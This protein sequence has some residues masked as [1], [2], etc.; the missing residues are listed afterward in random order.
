V[1][2]NKVN[3]FYL[4]LLF[5]HA[6]HVFEEAWGG[7]R[8]VGKIGL[9]WFFAVNWFLFSIPLVIFYFILEKRRGAYI[10]GMLYGA[11]MIINGLGH[12]IV[13]I[14]TGRYFGFAAGGFTGIGLILT[15]LP[16]VYYLNKE[17]R[18]SRSVAR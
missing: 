18:E 6:G 14:V 10:L 1:R 13:T 5:F 15:G 8:I 7:F 4:A 3:L 2:L 17:Y 12:N 9:G 16:L 11:F